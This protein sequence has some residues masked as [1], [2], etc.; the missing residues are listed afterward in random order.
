M[1]TIELRIP[2]ELT[3][4]RIKGMTLVTDEAAQEMAV[5]LHNIA[6]DYRQ[7]FALRPPSGVYGEFEETDVVE[8]ILRTAL[9]IWPIDGDACGRESAWLYERFSKVDGDELYEGYLRLFNKINGTN[10]TDPA[11]C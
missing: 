5:E 8:T 2:V 11:G 7:L 9:D 10:F 3:A 4:S 6:A 1:S